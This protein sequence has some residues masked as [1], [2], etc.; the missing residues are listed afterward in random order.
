MKRP[1]AMQ[2]QWA[3]TMLRSANADNP[4]DEAIW[5][6]LLRIDPSARAAYAKMAMTPDDLATLAA[7]AGIPAVTL[8]DIGGNLMT[9]GKQR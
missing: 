5:R 1:Y 8:P 2:L 6:D 9:L 3:A 7:S 4:N